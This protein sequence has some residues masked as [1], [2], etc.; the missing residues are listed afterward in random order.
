MQPHIFFKPEGHELYLLDQR[1]LPGREEWFICRNITDIV[2]ALKE[3]V[4]RGA[5]AIGVTAA[6]GCCLAAAKADPENRDWPRSLERDLDVLIQARPTAVNLAWAVSL[7]RR[8]WH[9]RP[10]MPLEELR[11]VWIEQAIALHRQDEADNRALGAYGAALLK[12]G[13]SVMTHCNAGALA[14]GAYGTAL[15]VI[16]AAVEAGKRIRVLVGETRPFL[17]GARL[18]A[19]ELTADGIAVTVC[20]DNAVGLL[21]AKGL[22]QVVVV[23]ADRVAANGDVANKIGTY[24]VAVLAKRHN[25]PFYVAA[26]FSSIDLA[27]PTGAQI[28]IEERAPREVTHIQD[29]MITPPGVPVLNFAFDITPAE[30][31]T[32]IITEKGVYEPDRLFKPKS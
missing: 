14:T 22:V 5:P 13:D 2:Y 32:A 28:P 23:G 27:T 16:R 17:Q 18:T 30:L 15:G 26:P 10:H 29:R 19:Y 8:T 24:T 31:I 25:V 11:R 6:Y 4:I 21:M 7:M 12:D 20:C 3:M 9:T 1:F